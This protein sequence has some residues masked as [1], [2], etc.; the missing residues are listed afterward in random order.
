MSLTPHRTEKLY[1]SEPYGT[2]FETT[3][4]TLAAWEEKPSLVLAKTLFYPEG[5]GQLGDSGTIAIGSSLVRIADTRIADDGTIHHV[6]AEPLHE[7]VSS[8]L[9]SAVT[10][11]GA[12]DASRRRDHM[13]QHTAQHAL[14]RALADEARA[15]TVSARL[16]AT[17]CTIDVARPTIPDIELH[18]AEDLVNALAASDVNV[19]ALYPSTT[20]LAKLPLRKQPKVEPGEVIRII[21]IEG[22]DMTPC[23]GTHCTK[24]SHIGQTRIV[25]L[26]K[27]KGGLRITFHAGGRALA[28]ARA[29]HAVLATLA[30]E[31][32]CGVLD[33]P[34]AVTKLRAELKGTRAQ[35]DAARTELAELLARQMIGALPETKKPIVVPVMRAEDDVKTLRVLA[36]KLTEDARVVA[37]CGATD[38]ASGELVLVVQRGKEGKLDC[39]AFLLEQAKVRSGRGGGRPERAEGRFARGTS[40]E[41]LAAAATSLI[42]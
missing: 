14:S 27:Y 34:Q 24:S 31:L 36:G 19:R 35:L 6:L 8:L 9:G 32:T 33:V 40:L 2:S 18:R 1:W 21:D 7:A 20:E 11:R 42:D 10:A 23:G 17:T 37:L 39:G 41:V 16:G 30:S 4:A 12:I 29:K 13:V 26:E 25:A 22:F 15:E 5:G 3:G 38:P 28:D